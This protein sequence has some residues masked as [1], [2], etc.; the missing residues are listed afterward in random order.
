M[1]ETLTHR[2]PDSAGSHVDGAVGL[3]A[4]RLA[5]IDLAGGDQPIANERGDVTVVQNGEIYNYA[6]ARRRAPRR[7]PPFPTASDTE[8][9][10]HLYEDE[11]P[12][13]VRRLRGMYAI[14]VWDAPRRRL[15][16]ARDPFGIK[17]LF[18][19]VDGDAARVRLG[20][21]GAARGPDLPARARP[22]GTRRLPRDEQRAGAAHDLPRRLEAAAGSRARGRRRG[23]ASRVPR[24][25]RARRRSATCAASRRRSSSASCST[26]S[27]T[28]SARTSWRTSTSA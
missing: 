16:L 15:V 21:E 23:R 12:A 28:P 19:R 5:I 25:A 4:R 2:G 20:A 13:F 8:V 26:G 6:R 18:Y 27:A 17:P 10:V 11:G 14:A 9:L 22:R 1:R 3:A 24:P 7:R